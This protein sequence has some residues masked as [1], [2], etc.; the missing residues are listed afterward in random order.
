MHRIE[1]KTDDYAIKAVKA[2]V[3]TVCDWSWNI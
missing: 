2:N 3:K 1:V